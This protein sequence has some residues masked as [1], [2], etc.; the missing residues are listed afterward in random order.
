LFITSTLTA[1]SLSDSV[2]FKKAFIQIVNSRADKFRSIVDSLEEP[3]ITLPG[4]EYSCSV[5]ELYNFD[6]SCYVFSAAYSLEDA[7]EAN[8]SYYA[9]LQ[10]VRYSLK[11]HVFKESQVNDK[12]E[13]TTFFFQPGKEAYADSYIEV[14]K[15][16]DSN[17]YY[18]K[19]NIHCR[20]A[21]IIYY[22]NKGQI[23]RDENYKQIIGKAIT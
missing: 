23:T 1:Q 10:L 17:N 2:E 11:P 4:A 12:D 13:S 14:I 16:K 7:S 18:V 6:D 15:E 20:P 19:L 22:A 21:R 9:I 8:H 3:T 5:E